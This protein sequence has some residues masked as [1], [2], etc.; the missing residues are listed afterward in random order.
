M[1]KPSKDKEKFD[2]VQQK[3]RSHSS[4]PY[5]T[6]IDPEHAGDITGFNMGSLSPNDEDR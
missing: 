3:I 5:S 4:L 2:G 6:A 1:I